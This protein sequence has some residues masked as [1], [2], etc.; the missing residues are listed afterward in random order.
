MFAFS[1]FIYLD[2]S[3]IQDLVNP[4]H[5]ARALR[6]AAPALRGG[7][8]FPSATTRG[9]AILAPT[10]WNELIDIRTAE[11]SHIFFRLKTHLFPLHFEHFIPSTGFLSHS[12]SNTRS[13][14]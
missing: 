4:Y 6:L 7:P 13:H 11:S 14:S 5:P 9:F 10:W 12:G 1:I 8:K 2:P 3:S